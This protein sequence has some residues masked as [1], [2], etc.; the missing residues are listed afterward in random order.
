MG[1]QIRVAVRVRPL[2]KQEQESGHAFAWNV[3]QN[4]ICPADTRDGGA[5]RYTLD[6]V[7]GPNWTTR[8]IYEVRAGVGWG[9]GVRE[10]R[11]GGG[12]VGRWVAWEDLQREGWRWHGRPEPEQPHHL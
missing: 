10:G 11:W 5:Q 2:S 6:H 8:R 1:D 12:G 4:S 9:G 7:F 3:Q